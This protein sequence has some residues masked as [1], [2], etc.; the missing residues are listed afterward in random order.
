[1]GLGGAA[2]AVTTGATAAIP[3]GVPDAEEDTGTPGKRGALVRVA[4]QV[5]G[6]VMEDQGPF[7][8][9]C[10]LFVGGMLTGIVLFALAIFLR[11]VLAG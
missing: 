5:S 4:G 11:T 10:I 1:M 6:G 9:R 8:D 3:G 2:V 7:L